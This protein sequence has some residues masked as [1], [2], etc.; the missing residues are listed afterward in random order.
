M[1]GLTSL[2][3]YQGGQPYVSSIGYPDPIGGIFAASAT[4]SALFDS[5]RKGTP[6]LVDL[7]QTEATTAMIGEYIVGY[8]STGLL[9]TRRGNR[10]P[11]YAPQGCYRCLGNDKW[12]TLTVRSEEEWCGLCRCIGRPDLVN[13]ARFVDREARMSNHDELNTLIEEWTAT[14]GHIEAMAALQGHGVPSGA[15]LNAPELLADDNLNSRGFFVTIKE[16]EAGSFPYPG[17]PVTVDGSRVVGRPAPLFGEHNDE[18]LRDLL[19]I[20]EAEIQ[21]FRDDGVLMDEPRGAR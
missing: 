7:A 4:V 11:F 13:D 14:M 16:T 1:T 18:I 3:G 10:H 12:V 8:Q 19:G 15:V 9:P 5:K 17:F 21:R 6:R 20:P 2:M